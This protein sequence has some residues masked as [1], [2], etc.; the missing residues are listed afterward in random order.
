MPAS[1]LFSP[2]ELRGVRARNRLVVSPMCQYS[3]RGGFANEWH[4]VHLGRFALGGFGIVFVEA[5]GVEAAGRITHGD[6]GLWSDEHAAPLARI[7]ALL[8]EQGA[9]PAIQLAHAGRKASAQRPWEGGGPLSDADLARGEAPWAT[10][11]ASALPHGEHWHLPR[12]ATAADLERIREAFVA[13]ARRALKA[14]F[15]AVEVHN[16][17]GYL[18]NQFL[19]PVANRRDDDYGGDIFG[20]MR[21]PLEVI[22]AVRRAWPEEKPVFVRISAVDRVPDI[23]WS[24]ADSI[25]FAARLKAIGVDV[26]DC[27]SGGFSQSAVPPPE[28]LYQTPYAQA[29]RSETGIKTMAVGLITNAAAAEAIV[30]ENRADLVAL[31]REALSDPNWPLHAQRALGGDPLDFS[32]WPIQA[33]LVLK[34]REKAFQAQ[35]GVKV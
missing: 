33:G 5:T 24:L 23:G 30:A 16:A 8:K 11:S 19:S 31:G 15:E 29:I 27:S 17:H 3:A 2:I 34:N 14:G 9:V 21:F 35:D 13:A 28:P 32:L 6:M 18:L 4:L 20:R 1:H 7:A 12:A 10:V 26:V 22:E 25:V